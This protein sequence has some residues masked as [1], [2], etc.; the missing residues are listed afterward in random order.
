MSIYSH[1][2]VSTRTA[3]VTRLFHKFAALL[4]A[5]GLWL[6]QVHIR[7]LVKYLVSR[8]RVRVSAYNA[9][10]RDWVR[11]RVGIKLEG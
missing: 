2:Y 8:V 1:S 6:E 4:Q 9:F 11:V 10:V 5:R 3:R 7:K